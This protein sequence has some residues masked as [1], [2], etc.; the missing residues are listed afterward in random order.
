L[1]LLV[2]RVQIVHDLED[3]QDVR[4]AAF[5]ELTGV[6]FDGQADHLVDHFTFF[7]WLLLPT[8]PRPFAF[9]EAISAKLDRR[10]A[11]GA[12]CRVAAGVAAEA[13]P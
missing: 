8:T 7:Q 10:V 1:Q 4:V 9:A 3:M 11:C 5:V 12:P 6:T 13:G 2:I